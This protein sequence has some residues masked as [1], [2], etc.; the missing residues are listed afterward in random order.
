MNTYLKNPSNAVW[1]RVVDGNGVK[2]DGYSEKIDALCYYPQKYDIPVTQY[3]QQNIAQW[4][5]DKLQVTT[6]TTTVHQGYGAF[7]WVDAGSE[8]VKQRRSQGFSEEDWLALV[9]IPGQTALDARTRAKNWWLDYNNANDIQTSSAPVSYQLWDVVKGGILDWYDPIANAVAQWWER[10]IDTSANCI[11]VYRGGYDYTAGIPQTTTTVSPQIAHTPIVSV[12]PIT[13][14]LTATG[15][16]TA[17]APLRAVSMTYYSNAVPAPATVSSAPGGATTYHFSLSASPDL[18]TA[19]TFYYSLHAVDAA[20][21]EIRAPA[22]GYY[23]AQVARAAQATF[24]ASGGQLALPGGNA[25]GGVASI[26]IPL[27]ALDS[28]Q[29]IT[30]LEVKPEDVGINPP[31]GKYTLGVDMPVVMYQFLP[32]G[33]TF[34]RPATITLLYPDDNNDNIVD[35]TTIDASQLSILWWNE[36]YQQWDYVGGVVDTIHKTITCPITHFSVYGVGFKGPLTD[37][38]YR[39]KEKIITPATIDNYNDFANFGGIGIDDSIYIYD[40]TGRRVRE[41][42]Q[43]T[44]RWDG[45]DQDGRIVESGIYIYQIKIHGKNKPISG[46]IVVA[47]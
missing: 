32:E 41:L 19:T 43:G 31:T 22:D 26:S 1:Y 18:S 24:N 25:F 30:F 36:T 10:F 5:V 20:G 44:S 37:N 33:L 8:T 2:I 35:G 12:S 23:A 40:V 34:A 11:L 39:P 21:N 16:I 3:A 45:K 17:S 13:G 38:D 7:M 46:T 27:G 15:T 29:T 6:A 14:V 9:D 47:K 42:Q 28:N 4:M